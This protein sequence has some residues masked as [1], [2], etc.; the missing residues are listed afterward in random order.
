MKN[1]LSTNEKYII[2]GML[3]DK[4]EAKDIASAIHRKTKTVQDY[5]DNE[6]DKLHATIVK[7]E[8][9][10]S[11]EKAEENDKKAVSPQTKK[12]KR[13][14]KNTAFIHKTGAGNPGV[15]INNGTA[16]TT[17]DA[18]KGLAKT[19]RTARGNI[20]QIDEEEILE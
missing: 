6:L 9:E 18:H 1:P 16:S 20:Y 4:H 14:P 15:A 19:A 8:L 17:S 10:K 12:K 2:Q 13:K 3:V 7:I 11:Q 5:I